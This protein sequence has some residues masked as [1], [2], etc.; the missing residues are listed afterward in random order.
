[1][2]GCARPARIAANSSRVASTDLS[3]LPSASLRMSL[4]TAAPSA[5]QLVRSWVCGSASADERANLL[6]LDGTQ[7]VALGLHAEHE[8]RELVLPAQGEG[9]LVHDAQPARHRLVVGELVELRRGRVEVGVCGV[10]AV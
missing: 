9:R 10:D 6:T 7:D 4:I 3:I 8:H 1:M 5:I 2:L